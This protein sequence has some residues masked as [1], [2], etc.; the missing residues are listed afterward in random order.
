MR[1]SHCERPLQE[2]LVAS[3]A[4]K[5]RVRGSCTRNPSRR[6]RE[7]K[8]C[9]GKAPFFQG[10]NQLRFSIDSDNNIT[11]HGP[12]FEAAAANG[13]IFSTAKGLKAIIESSPGARGIE[14]WNSLPGVTPASAGATR[15]AERGR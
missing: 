4:W 15:A 10:D 8:A 14:I 9:Q 12:D 3:V 1:G 6:S 2:Q 5:E 13:Q 11:A 7:T